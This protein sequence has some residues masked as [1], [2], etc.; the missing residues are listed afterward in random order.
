MTDKEL[1][2][3]SRAELLE[4]LLVQTRQN[5]QLR[6]ELALAQ[7]QLADRRLQVENA[8][9]LAHAVLEVN[10]V[11]EA[12]QAAAQQYLDNI[13]AMEAETKQRCEKMLLS[14]AREASR[15]R[16]DQ[17]EITGDPYEI[18]EDPE[19]CRGGAGTEPGAL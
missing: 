13:A 6:E 15:I 10:A 18:Y 3:L 7:N 4:L 2:R 1:K 5:E 12:A 8:G 9:D 14:A 19:F 11:M 17:M 16:E